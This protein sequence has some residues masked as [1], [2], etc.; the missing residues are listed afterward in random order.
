MKYKNQKL[1]LEINEIGVRQRQE[2]QAFGY[3]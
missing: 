1:D 2:N 3:K